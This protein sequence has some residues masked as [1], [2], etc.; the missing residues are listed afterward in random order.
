MKG[1]PRCRKLGTQ[2]SLG[3]LRLHPSIVHLQ[4]LRVVPITPIPCTMLPDFARNHETRLFDGMAKRWW[5]PSH[6]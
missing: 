2:H 3:T 5:Y 4:R 1:N 6:F